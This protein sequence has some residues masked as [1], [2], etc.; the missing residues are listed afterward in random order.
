MICD[1]QILISLAVISFGGHELVQS[2]TQEHQ[3]S[4]QTEVV[5][6]KGTSVALFL[7]GELKRQGKNP[8]VARL[9]GRQS[10][11]DSKGKTPSVIVAQDVVVDGTTVIARGIPVQFMIG[12]EPPGHMNAPGRVMFEVTGV[13]S[14]SLD[15][16]HLSAVQSARG[17]SRFCEDPACEALALAL[18]WVHGDPG[19]IKAG[20][21]F[22]AYVTEEITLNRDAMPRSI[23]TAPPSAPGRLHLYQVMQEPSRRSAGNELGAQADDL[24]GGTTWTTFSIDGE[25]VGS[26]EGLQYACVKVSPG[27]HMLR[28]EHHEYRFDVGEHQEVYVRVISQ[29]GDRVVETTDGYQL[30]PATLEP[31]RL[32]RDSSTPCFDPPDDFPCLQSDRH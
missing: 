27:S 2:R 23:I 26:L 10:D 18:S 4:S 12:G 28:I 21:L 19:K 31:G 25:R 22:N 8:R 13:R 16:V 1:L 17:K 7:T 6:P 15:F 14:T 32:K 20:L 24:T 5:I 3:P 11:G 29:G 9:L 30:G